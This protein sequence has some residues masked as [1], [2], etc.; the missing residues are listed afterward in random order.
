MTGSPPP[1]SS[2]AH[3]TGSRPPHL[4][5]LQQQMLANQK[6]RNVLDICLGEK[7]NKNIWDTGAG[8]GNYIWDIYNNNNEYSERL[9]RTGPKR[10]HVLYKYIFVKIQY[11]QHE[12]THT[13]AH[14]QTRTHMRTCTKQKKRKNNDKR[15]KGPLTGNLGYTSKK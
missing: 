3:L 10:L 7:K 6:S 1:D 2:W 8:G 15:V 12:C 9:T 5:F 13:H 11:T 4:H 14:T